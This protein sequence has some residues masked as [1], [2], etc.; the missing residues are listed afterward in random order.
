MQLEFICDLELAYREE[1]LIEGKFL[2]VRPY[3]GEEGTGYGEG[4]GTVTGPQLQ[5]TLR[6]VNHPHRRSD[7]SMLPDAHGII[8]T[9]DQAVIMFTL[10]GRTVF[11]QGIGKQLLSV[12]FEAEAEPYRWLNSTFCVLEGLIDSERLR[13]RARIYACR[14]DLV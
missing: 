9:H 6:W 10:Q 4:D 14:S 1:P 5:G 8:V 3:G 13:M 2:L 12:I 11:E 7:G